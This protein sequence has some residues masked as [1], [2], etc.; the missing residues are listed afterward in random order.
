MVYLA[1]PGTLC[2]VA[3]GGLGTGVSELV[4]RQLGK[5]AR[6]R[7]PSV[8]V[9][10]VCLGQLGR[11]TLATLATSQH[12][13]EAAELAIWLTTNKEATTL[14]TTKQFLFPVLND[15]LNSPEFANKPFDFYGGQQVNQIFIESAKNVDP[16]FQWS[17]FQD[18]VNS[19]MGDEFGRPRAGRELWP[20][21]SIAC[22]KARPI[23]AGSRVHREDLTRPGLRPL[24]AAQSRFHRRPHRR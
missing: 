24:A 19:T 21:R 5:V 3:D 23:C 2:D 11:S 12:P 17:P 20:K 10:Q 7:D 4:A 8:G 22:R 6:G 16:S 1:R 14:Y 9:R 13:K 15:L 18:Y